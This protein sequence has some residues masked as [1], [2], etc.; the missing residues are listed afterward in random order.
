MTA[1]GIQIPDFSFARDDPAR[2]FPATVAIARTAEQAGFSS[3]WVM[4]HFH[5][6]VPLSTPA[7]PMPE[8]Y[9]LLAGL[10][11][12]TTTI[13]LGTLVTGVTYRNPALLAKIV[14]T[15]DVVS[16]GRAWLGVGASWNESEY[17]AYGFGEDLPGT[18]ERLDRLEDA[19][20][21]ARA[22]FAGPATL[23][24]HRIAVADAHNSPAPVRPG[25]PP[26]MIGGNG[27]RRLLRLVARYGDACNVFGSPADVRDLMSVLDAHCAEVGRDP[28]EIHRTRLGGILVAESEAEARRR[29]DAG[30]FTGSWGDNLFLGTPEQVREKA[31][32]YIDAGLDGL[33]VFSAAGGWTPEDVAAAGE[34]LAPLTA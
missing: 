22:M 13:E 7:D 19:L 16:G 28:A 6:I 10:A 27:R 14:T 1:I 30:G 33:L 4:D 29:A 18:R 8:G 21:I 11:A 3:L 26:I 2:L 32:A 25:G 20:R 17:R 12:S 23:R 34:A 5:Q 15:L 31:Q 24:G 9:T